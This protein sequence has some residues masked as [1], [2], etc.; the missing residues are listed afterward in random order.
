MKMRYHFFLFLFDPDILWVLIPL[1]F[2]LLVMMKKRQ[3]SKI[4]RRWK[5]DER[6][7]PP[8]NSYD[9]YYDGYYDDKDQV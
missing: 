9:Q 6:I 4:K 5:I 1:L 7:N 2:I 8:D 3:S